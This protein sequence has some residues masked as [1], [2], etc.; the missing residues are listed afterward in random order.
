MGVESHKTVAHALI[1]AK[2]AL[3][4]NP[5]L[6]VHDF[7]P[8]IFAAVSEIYGSQKSAVDPFHVMQDLNRAIQKDI[9]RFQTRQFR[10]E[11]KELKAL[12]N[13]INGVQKKDPIFK[14][15]HQSLHK[16]PSCERN[17]INSLLCQKITQ[18][19]LNLL[20]IQDKQLF[21][22]KIRNYLKKLK[23][24]SKVE[25]SRFASNMERK[26]P[27]WVITEKAYMRTMKELFKKL[28]TFYLCFRKPFEQEKKRFNKKRWAIFYQ[29]ENLTPKRAPLLTNLLQKYPE[30]ES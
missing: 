17:H 18:K 3:G 14:I 1:H 26:L 22:Q 21:F 23:S 29:P 8:N 25:V 4:I 2:Y 15:S 30:L 24:D 12:R 13:F 20:T 9:S 19:V 6:V 11:L 10:S 27:K 5:E 7:S 16:L 28:K